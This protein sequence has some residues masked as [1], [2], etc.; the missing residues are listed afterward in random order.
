VSEELRMAMAR[1]GLLRPEVAAEWL[2]CSRS[3]VFR[4]IRSGELRSLR[5]GGLRRVSADE[6]VRFVDAQ[7]A[8][9]V[10]NGPDAA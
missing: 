1:R 9:Q 10:D 4:L 2:S 7:M 3:Q 6:L 5:V 8:S